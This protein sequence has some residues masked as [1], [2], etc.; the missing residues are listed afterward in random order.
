MYIKNSNKTLDVEKAT[1]ETPWAEGPYK[2]TLLPPGRKVEKSVKVMLG[3]NLELEGSVNG[4]PASKFLQ[5]EIWF[6]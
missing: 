1:L 5:A 3:E 4:G 2:A 6:L